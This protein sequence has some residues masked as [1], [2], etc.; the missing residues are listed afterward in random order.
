MSHAAKIVALLEETGQLVAAD[1]AVAEDLGHQSRAYGLAG[2]RGN[3]RRTPVRVPE[4]VV[5]T[6]NSHDDEPGAF[7]TLN[8]LPA[9]DDRQAGHAGTETR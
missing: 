5:A 9:C 8:E 7:Q 2:V 3:N 6:S 1:L 4:E